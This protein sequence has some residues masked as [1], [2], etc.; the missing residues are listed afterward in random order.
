MPGM[1]IRCIGMVVT[2]EG[3]REGFSKLICSKKKVRSWKQW[4]LGMKRKE[5]NKNKKIEMAIH[6]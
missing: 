2:E 4:K 1:Q 3:K 6:L 5:R